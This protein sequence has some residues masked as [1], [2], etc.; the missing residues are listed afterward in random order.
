MKKA[1]LSILL[2]TLLF[3]CINSQEISDVFKQVIMLENDAFDF[4]PEYGEILRGEGYIPDADFDLMRIKYREFIN[5]SNTNP[6]YYVAY[7][8]TFHYK[9]QNDSASFYFAKAGELAGTDYAVH[10]RLYQIYSKHVIQ[11]AMD[12][13]IE[14][15]EKIKYKIGAIALPEVAQYLNI[16]A[17]E[18]YSEKNIDRAAEYLILANKLDPYNPDIIENLFNLTIRE[19]R[20]EYIGYA[21][22]MLKDQLSESFNKFAFIVNVLRY[23]RYLILT[24]FFVM[25]VMLFIRISDKYMYFFKR[26]VRL[27]LDVKQKSFLGLLVLFLPLILQL[28]PVIWLFYIGFI[29]FLLTEK[30]ERIIMILMLLL[31]SLLPQIFRVENSVLGMMN[32]DDNVSVM[33]KAD[34]TYWD[35]KLLN[36]INNLIDEQPFNTPLLFAKAKL[37]KKGG[38]FENAENEYNKILL[39]K[40]EFGELY[41]NIGNIM[42]LNGYYAKAI[43]NYKKATELSPTL[44]Q[45]YYNLGQVYLKKMELTVSDDYVR[46]GKEMNYELVSSFI[47]NAEEKYYNTEII[48]CNIPE[49]FI[50]NEF[51]KKKKASDSPV[52]MGV[53]IN[54]LSFL[55]ICLII[56]ASILIFFFRKTLRIERCH[57]CGKPISEGDRRRF[58]EAYICEDDFKGLE[59][60]LSDVFKARKF[61][62]LIR[63]RKKAFFRKRKFFSLIFPGFGKILEGRTIKGY[64]LAV[65]ASVLILLLFSE[66]LLISKNPNLYIGIHFEYRFVYGGLILFLYL[67]SFIITKEEK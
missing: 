67:I 14:Q 51:L 28:N 24:V 7:G 12:K 42:Y 44:A 46:K 65:T 60:T 8:F 35:I 45:P 16:S 66:N 41:N 3:V 26:Y 22:K 50:W 19:R 29:V 11:Y 57:T 39:K 58:S 10:L 40:D 25:T 47:E 53:N 33:I 32:P 13:E 63:L 64:L 9:K 23:S 21:I 20:F 56:F 1:K 31:V 34:N 52:M 4:Y 38:Y 27:P 61:E 37:F 59:E 48:D 54:I 6:F 43:E 62:S 2:L 15:F 17:I 36:K 5:D 30:K 49:K 55:A 18:E